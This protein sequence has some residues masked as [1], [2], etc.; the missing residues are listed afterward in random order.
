MRNTLQEVFSYLKNPTIEKDENKEFSYRIKKFGNLL[1][2]SILT[3]ILI[4]PVFII[5][6]EMGFINMENHAIEEMVKNYT[7]WQIVLF[8]VILAPLFEELFFRAPI[9]AFKNPK[10]FKIGFYFF[11]FL[12][13]FIHITNFEITKSVIILAPILVAPQ[14]L[15]GGYLGFIRVKF[16]LIWSIALHAAYNGLLTLITFIPDLL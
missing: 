2:I 7:K 16:G 1:I 12:F 5:I 14:I 9:T 15:L 4:S 8:T 3:G 10:F 13:G 6:E 11:T